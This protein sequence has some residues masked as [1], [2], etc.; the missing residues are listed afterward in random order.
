[1]GDDRI[2]AKDVAEDD[3]VLDN[4][5]HVDRPPRG[6]PN[7]PAHVHARQGVVERS[8]EHLEGDPGQRR[9]E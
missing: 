6:E 4:D 1:M 9:R 2:G 7:E 8:R 5:R 3:W